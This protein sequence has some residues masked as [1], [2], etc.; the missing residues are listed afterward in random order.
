ME[1][2]PEVM[3]FVFL[4]I[5]A[6]SLFSFLAVASFSDARRRERESYYKND[7]LK[8]LADAQ[9]PGATSA[10][11]LMREEA[12]LAAIHR[13]QGLKIAGL[14]LVG[15]GLGLVIFLKALISGAP[16]YLCGLLVL[17]IGIALFASSYMV[18]APV[19][20]SV[21]AGSR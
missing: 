4:A 16:V 21:L 8:K 18:T 7:M 3:I 13:K 12:R 9:G 17:L 14:V 10:I 5:G 2:R 15:T 11:Q 19:E 20:D 6:V 1:W